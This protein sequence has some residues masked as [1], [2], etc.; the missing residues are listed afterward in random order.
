MTCGCVG[1]HRWRNRRQG[2]KEDRK[3]KRSSRWLKYL[4]AVLRAVKLCALLCLS[5]LTHGCGTSS[6][7]IAP[8]PDHLHAAHLTLGRCKHSF[9]AS[10]IDSHSVE[11]V[12]QPP[13]F[14]SV[15]P[16]SSPISLQGYHKRKQVSLLFEFCLYNGYHKTKASMITVQTSLPHM[17]LMKW[18]V[19]P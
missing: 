8:A 17:S 10:C 1:A 3:V 12:V 19:C 18:L 7:P 5:L 9:I 2:L 6:A 16:V 15:L 4:S 13:G 14:L 11:W